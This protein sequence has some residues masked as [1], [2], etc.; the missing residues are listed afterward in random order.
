MKK[1]REESWNQK[2]S[3]I[4]KAQV[5]FEPGQEQKENHPI[6]IIQLENPRGPSTL[7]FQPIG[8]KPTGDGA[9]ETGMTKG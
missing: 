9:C 7:N 5:R 3:K 8:C 6:G 1:K 4:K 2:K